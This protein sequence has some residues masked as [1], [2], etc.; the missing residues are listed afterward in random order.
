MRTI[1]IW[2]VFCLTRTNSQKLYINQQLFLSGGVNRVVFE[3]NQMPKKDAVRLSRT[4]KYLQYN[5]AGVT[6][7]G[8]II[9][10][11]DACY[12]QTGALNNILTLKHSRPFQ[13]SYMLICHKSAQIIGTCS[14]RNCWNWSR[15]SCERCT[16]ETNLPRTAGNFDGSNRSI[17]FHRRTILMLENP[18][19]QRTEIIYKPKNLTPRTKCLLTIKHTRDLLQTQIRILIKHL[20]HTLT[21][22]IGEH[23][24]GFMAEI[25]V[26]ESLLAMHLIKLLIASVVPTNW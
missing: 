25:G 16:R 15:R 9:Q 6:D 10:I 17:S 26:Q 1:L 20:F 7:L 21:T 4:V 13:K 11:M 2:G 8:Q 24:H 3:S 5:N 18:M 12:G 19:D 14:K 22:I 23:L